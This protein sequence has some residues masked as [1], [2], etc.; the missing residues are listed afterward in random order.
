MIAL[1]IV[2]ITLLLTWLVTNVIGHRLVTTPY[3]RRSVFPFNWMVFMGPWYY[4]D[5]IDEW[6]STRE[7]R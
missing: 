6:R 3:E 7:L 2:L 5:H 1:L 4:Y